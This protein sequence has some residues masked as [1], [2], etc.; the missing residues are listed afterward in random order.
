MPSAGDSQG[1]AE[2]AG[3]AG[4]QL[5]DEQARRADPVHLTGVDGLLLVVP[6]RL[7]GHI[8]VEAARQRD[9]DHIGLQRA[10]A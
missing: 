3:R 7:V 5:V 2:T 9:Q 6:L 4:R 10:E 1:T 8:G